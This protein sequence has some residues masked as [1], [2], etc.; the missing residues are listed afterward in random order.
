MYAPHVAAYI[1]PYCNSR[2]VYAV[3][4][5]YVCVDCGTVVDAVYYPPPAA[6]RDD[7][8][9]RRLAVRDENAR[10]L[11]VDARRFLRFARL[12]DLVDKY[13]L[14]RW[15]EEER[16]RKEAEAPRRVPRE[17]LIAKHIDAI[18]ADAGI[19]RMECA[20]ALELHRDRRVR[21]ALQSAKAK[22][23]A[24]A[25]LAVALRVPPAAFGKYANPAQVSKLVK[26]IE[27]RLWRSSR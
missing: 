26:K 5:H 16:R 27:A 21:I 13:D 18:C 17:V 10:L 12:A 20:K 6:E 3:D 1:C 19:P 15:A 9:R 24:A 22:T 14:Y 25:L 8:V 11:S 23:V 4:G 2:H 7:A